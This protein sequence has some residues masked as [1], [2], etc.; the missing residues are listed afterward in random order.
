VKGT[1]A[2]LES[3]LNHGVN[4][5]FGYPGGNVIPLF[6]AFLTYENKIK[7]ILV[8]HEQG[9]AHA[10][11]GFARASGTPGICIATSGPGAS[12]L[13]TG[14]MTAFMDS[15]PLI[16][17]AGQ[18][19]VPLIGNDAFQ[20]TDMMSMTLSITKHNL[21]PRSPDDIGP[22]FSKAYAIATQGRPGP[23]YMDLPLDTQT[24]ESAP[25]SACHPGSVPDMQSPD[26]HAISEAAQRIIG[27]QRP[28]F[29]IGG[30]VIQSNASA[31]LHQLVDVVKAPVATTLMGKGAYDEHHPFS[32]GMVG[33]HGRRIANYALTTCDVLI[34]IGCRLIDR[35][36]GNLETFATDCDIIHIDIDPAE[37]G[38]NVQPACEIVGDAKAIIS[39]LISA[40][41]SRCKKSQQSE[42]MKRIHE[43][44]ELCDCSESCELHSPLTPVTILRVLSKELHPR[45]IV[46]TGVGQHQMYCAHFLQMQ[47]PRTFIT[48]G[49]A[50][51][52]GFGLPASIGAKVARPGSEVYDIDGDGSFQ[53]TCQ[54]LGT[55]AAERIKVN[56]IIL[57]NHYLGMVRQWLELFF[58]KRYSQVSL[59]TAVDFVHLAQAYGFDG[60]TVTRPAE[61]HDALKTQKASKELFLINCEIQQDSNIF[62]MLPP[63]GSLR[64]A[65]GGCM[66]A[67]GKFF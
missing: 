58:D 9:A 33:M 8:R 56:P 14:I 35:V 49:G 52:M 15:S 3:M 50:G 11:D 30:G 23:V 67:P 54:E 13:I 63:A 48:S 55:C 27:A 42:W 51:T 43:F 10:A 22:L 17:M 31:V 5:T 37:I 20:E 60:S 47:T 2:L 45:D 16:A 1:E 4:T 53:M 24:G 19:T 29:L 7:N 66:K 38:K 61:L 34:V 40:L 46:C 21:Q 12:N 26:L 62:P 28:L 59:G 65:F 41:R 25:S 44:K 6:D 39:L 18:V 32:L 57:S 64:D 36:T